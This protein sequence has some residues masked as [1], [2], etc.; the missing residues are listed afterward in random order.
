MT[1][2]VDEVDIALLDVLHAEPR[3]SF[4]E[5]ARVLGVSGVT[6]ARRWQRLERRGLAW[7]SSAPGPHLRWAGAL[8]EAQC[9]PAMA[10]NVADQ[11]ACVPQVLSVHIT[12]GRYNVYALI[13]AADSAA[14]TEL[15]MNVLPS[16]TGIQAVRSASVPQLLSGA[17]WRLGAI[18]AQ[19]RRE[20]T[21][22]AAE[23]GGH[24]FD[25]FDRRLYLALQQD[26]RLSYRELGLQLG[27]TE[28]A[29][30]RRLQLLVRSGLLRFR[31][32]F[33]RAEAGW[34]TS[35]VLRLRTGSDDAAATVGRTLVAWPE[36]RVC[37]E[38]IGG[39][40]DLFITVQLH[41]PTAL[42]A[43]LT[44]LH[45]T[46]PT[47]TVLGRRVVLRHVKSFGRLLDSTGHAHGVVPVDLWA[48]TRSDDRI[49]H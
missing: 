5:A 11:W 49:L 9:L 2:A 16:V 28:V 27:C 24:V 23:P 6:A 45:R 10:Q 19:Q 36:T 3:V 37:A 34:I 22:A 20:V 31:T 13:G 4:D 1:T 33:A 40:A 38:I 29:A 32:D 18:S 42:E 14:L 8:V 35:V 41:S 12:T 46:F 44:R 48:P 39:A 17:T 47:L 30:R 21:A 7:I 15:V 43:V 25:D 26:G